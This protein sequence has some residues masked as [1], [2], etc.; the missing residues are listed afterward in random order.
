VDDEEDD[1]RN[2]YLGAGC[3]GVVV[4]GLVVLLT[5]VLTQPPGSVRLGV[6]GNNPRRASRSTGLALRIGG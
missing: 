3:L 1:D 6:P 5:Q 2:T 4:A